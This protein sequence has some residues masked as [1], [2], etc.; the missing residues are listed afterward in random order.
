MSSTEAPISITAKTAAGT[1]VTLRA[2][3]AEELG[4]LVAQGIFAIADAVKEIELN[5][6][7][8]GN[9][10]VPPSPV[11]GM[12]ANTLGGTVISETPA[13]A[14]GGTF[15]VRKTGNE[16]LFIAGGGS[17]ESNSGAGRDGVLTRLGGTST[18]GQ[19]AGGSVGFGGR[20]QSPLGY[21]AA[22]GGFF[23]ML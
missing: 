12:I 5:V 3:T 23:L 6:R 17:A 21:S 14:S 7:G 2:E 20:A 15:V 9:A 19:Q 22:G 8:A 18:N 11:V 4:N 16:P 13:P 10:A 1:L